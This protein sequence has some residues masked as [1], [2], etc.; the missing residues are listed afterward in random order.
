MAKSR[1]R[2]KKKGAGVDWRAVWGVS[3]RVLSV[4]L[5]VAVGLGLT[6]GVK[7]IRAGASEVL[8]Q[9]GATGEPLSVSFDWPPLAGDP[10]STW[11]PAEDQSALVSAARWAAKDVGPLSP[12]RVE[13]ISRT[14]GASGW[15]AGDPVVRVTGASSVEVDAVWRTPIAVVRWTFPGTDGPQDVL[16]SEGVR[17][18]PPQWR[19]PADRPEGVSGRPV[20]L[21]AS[22]APPVDSSVSTK[23]GT[24]W[25]G[26]DI[27]AGLDLIRVL[28]SAGLIDHIDGVDVGAHWRGGPL[29]IVASSGGRI[30]WGSAP[31]EWKTGEPSVAERV[32]RLRGLIDRTGRIDGGERR[33]SINTDLV[34][35][36]RTGRGGSD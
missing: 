5:L 22:E 3:A 13:R 19:V 24:P 33:I 2:K 28:L 17:R 18:M 29:E 4:A 15:F 10:R 6:I 1:S 8:A 27:R 25:P 21:G 9:R 30:V 20:I 31:N 14:L 26:P 34:E 35:I 23:Y 7:S 32:N 36:D 11:L 16:I 12:V